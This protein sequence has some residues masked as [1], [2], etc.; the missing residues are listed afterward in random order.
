MIDDDDDDDDDDDE[1]DDDD[2]KDDGNDDDGGCGGGDDTT[3]TGCLPYL[4]L[5]TSHMEPVGNLIECH[6][7]RPSQR[8]YLIIFWVGPT[9]LDAAALTNSATMPSI[10]AGTRK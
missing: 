4:T 1:D 9:S 2:D 3:L 7:E 6:C 10:I 8:T 5:F